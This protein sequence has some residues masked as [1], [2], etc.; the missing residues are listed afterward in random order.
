MLLSV[1]WYVSVLHYVGLWQV[2][3]E[4][5]HASLIC[6]WCIL[7]CHKAFT[8]CDVMHEAEF[9]IYIV[10][11]GYVTRRAAFILNIR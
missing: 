8:Y 5:R 4:C 3:M 6:I 11:C 9:F 2:V 1:V 7:Y 10:L